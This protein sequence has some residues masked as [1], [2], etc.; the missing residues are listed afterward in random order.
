MSLT[1]INKQD[2]FEIVRD[3]IAAI[4]AAESVQQM[5]LAEQENLD[6]EQWRLRVYT[7]RFRAWEQY[8]NNPEGA[9]LAPIVNV[10]FED[11][12]YDKSKS[13]AI[14]R[15]H[16][17]GTFNI[18]CYG[19][20]IA[21]DNPDG[22]HFAGDQQAALNCQRAV[23]LVRNILMASENTYLQMRGV[24][25]GTRW[26]RNVSTYQPQ[27]ENRQVQEVHATRISLEVP[28]NEFSPQYQARE[29]DYLAFDVLR[30]E[31]GELYFEAD[32]DYTRN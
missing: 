16:T 26:I 6:P 27:L 30:S 24:V 14:Q 2:N 31:T 7:E 25:W 13:D 22:G 29:L 19:L 32:Y 20:G 5:Q 8:L 3:Q 17:T 15:Q 21:Q 10:W 1:L 4:L 11:A 23:R 18:D 12:D 28:F 9:D